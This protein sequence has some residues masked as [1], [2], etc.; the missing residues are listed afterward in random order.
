M[1]TVVIKI[2]TTH[3]ATDEQLVNLKQYCVKYVKK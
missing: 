3:V 2:P 1:V